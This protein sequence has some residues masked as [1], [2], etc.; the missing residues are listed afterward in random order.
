MAEHLI[1]FCAAA[2]LQLSLGV[3]NTRVKWFTPGEV[4]FWGVVIFVAAEFIY[5]GLF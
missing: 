3:L 5:L 4:R 2:P 1:V